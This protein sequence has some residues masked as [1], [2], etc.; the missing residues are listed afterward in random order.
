MLDKQL[1]ILEIFKINYIR[2][3]TDLIDIFPEEEDLIYI[4]VLLTSQIPVSTVMDIFIESILPIKDMVVRRDENFFLEKC[5]L[6]DELDGTKVVHFKKLWSSPN[7]DDETKDV[8]W[9]YFD[10]LIGLTENYVNI[11]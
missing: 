11:N 6:F 5:N 3:F 10:V 4:R 8:M 9:K 7:L 1:K 2:F